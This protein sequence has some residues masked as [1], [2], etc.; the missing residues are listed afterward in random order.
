M[1]HFGD[2][3]PAQVYYV[4]LK[5]RERDFKELSAVNFDMTREELASSLAERFG[6]FPFA[7]SFCLDDEPVCIWVGITTHPGVWSIGLWATPKFP[8]IAKFVTKMCVTHIFQA[9]METGCHRIEC[10]SIVGYNAVHKWLLFLG[11][12]QSEHKLEKYGKNG[13]DF[14]I[15]EWIEG[16]APPG[17]SLPAE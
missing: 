16:M 4:S 7:F 10:K 17:S 6:S 5:M 3:T 1:I 13:E 11:F 14:L 8:K 15:F 2:A 9:I 12:R